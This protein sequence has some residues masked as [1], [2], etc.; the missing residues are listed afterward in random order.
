MK[1]LKQ[2]VGW[3]I[4]SGLICWCASAGEGK[5][6]GTK[7]LRDQGT[8]S[9]TDPR[10]EGAVKGPKDQ[11]TKGPADQV[12]LTNDCGQEL[13]RLLKLASKPISGRSK[14]VAQC[15]YCEDGKQI[16]SVGVRR[17][18]GKSLPGGR[19]EQ[20]LVSFRCTECGEEFSQVETCYVAEVVI[21]RTD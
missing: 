18:G 6:Q 20:W 4:L 19:E 21:R 3:L 14:F 15:P 13:M 5:D 12:T 7:G 1:K 2:K 11:G 10:K 16:R 9:P 8:T 17:T